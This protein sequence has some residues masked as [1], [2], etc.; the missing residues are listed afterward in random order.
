MIFLFA[1]TYTIQEVGGGGVGGEEAELVV[2][3]VA[4]AASK[5]AHPSDATEYEH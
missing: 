5:V 3:N 4:A 2:G 1:G